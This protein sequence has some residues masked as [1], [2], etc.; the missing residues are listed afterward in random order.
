[1]KERSQILDTHRRR[2]KQIRCQ[3]GTG[4]SLEDA[5]WVMT[6]TDAFVDGELSTARTCTV[7][8]QNAGLS[9]PSELFLSLGTAIQ[10]ILYPRTLCT[11]CSLVN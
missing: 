2:Y 11:V 6:S 4:F 1:M 9:D 3:R 10:R 5:G 8:G 7:P